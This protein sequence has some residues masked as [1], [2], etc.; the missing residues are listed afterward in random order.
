MNMNDNIQKIGEQA[1]EQAEEFKEY[2]IGEL[3]KLDDELKKKI[4]EMEKTTQSKEEL[5]AKIQ[6]DSEKKQWLENFQQQLDSVLKIWKEEI[7]W[8]KI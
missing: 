6:Q 1:K 5:E 4:G 7:F 3:E 2:F 8:I